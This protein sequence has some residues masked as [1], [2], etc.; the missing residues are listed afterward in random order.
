MVNREFL[1]PRL[2]G[3]LALAI[4]ALGIG[5]LTA[6]IGQRPGRNAADDSG[7]GGP[8]TPWPRPIPVRLEPEGRDDI[9]VSTLGEVRTTLADGTFDPVRDLVTADDGRVITDYYKRELDVP[10][11]EPIDKR[12]FPLPPSGWCSWYYYYQEIDADEVLANARWIA[13][14]LA[15]YGARYVQIDDGWQGTGHGL[16]DNRDW[17]TID[18]R[19]REPGMPAIADSI[20]A[21][22][23]EAGLWLAPHGQS[24]EEVARSS[25]A[26]LWRSDGSSASETWE[27]TYLIDPTAPASQDYLRDLF[28]RLVDWGYSYFKIDGQPIV[29]REFATKQEFMA[30]PLPEGDPEVVAARLYRKTL[31]TIRGAI[32]Q[33]SYL[34]G[35]WG[36]PLEGMGILNGSRTAGDI[37]QSW[38]GFLVA[39]DAVQRWQFLHNVAWYSDPDVILVRPPLSEGTARAWATIQG[40][41]GQALM[42]SDRMTDLPASRVELLRRI[43]PAVDIRPL[44]LYRPNNVRKPLWDLKVSHLGREYDVVAVFNFEMDEA[45]SRLVSW[46]ELGL[47][48]GRAYHVFDFWDGTY[49]GAWEHGIFL[50]TPPADVRVVTLVPEASRPTLVSTSRHI[51][52]GWV[53]LLELEESLETRG[54]PL[55]SGRSRVV[56]GDPY[57]LTVGLPRAAPTFRLARVNVTGSESRSRIEV[58]SSTHQGYAAVTIESDVDQ[59]VSWRMEFEPAEPYIFPVI[60]PP[61]LQVEQ[62]GLAGARLRWP[63]QYHAK[64]GYR[65]ELDGRPLGIA[66]EPWAVLRGLQAGQRHEFAVR[67]IWY[68]GSLGESEAEAAMKFSVPRS[69]YLSDLEPLVARQDWGRLGLDHSVEGNPLSVGGR[70]YDRGLGTHS[71]S[72]IRYDI[73]G[74]FRRFRAR[75]GIDDEVEPP[76][77]VAVVFEVWGDGRRLWSTAPIHSGDDPLPVD[78]D[79][80]GVRL[81]T[82]RVLPT[83]DGID[84]DH[85]DWLE[86]RLTS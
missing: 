81:L 71:K 32:G 40:L 7:Q 56:G 35:C 36:I 74:A 67:S 77:A 16:G 85:A 60:S 5:A 3:A 62:R 8:V 73:Y 22:G 14:N 65:V 78:L 47:D 24:N 15:P 6:M 43:Y 10:Y 17:T 63:T 49:L 12:R 18:V 53:D 38:D 51:T 46:E 50:I 48:P 69:V 2:A 21:L 75:V 31:R 55:L 1:R 72:E 83:E 39:N 28:Q 11:F 34:L 54:S 82:L 27:G 76:E 61:R 26:F 59:V 37:V 57:R 68:D 9:L 58:A 45:E 20:H 84:H 13:E 30:G 70:V 86:A 25:G 66:T 23:L 33:D 79:V 4:I 41:S 64:A 42:A 44:D 80:S 29:L 19:F 52:Q